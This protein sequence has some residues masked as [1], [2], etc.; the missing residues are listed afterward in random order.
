MP[1]IRNPWAPKPEF[2]FCHHL[3]RNHSINDRTMDANRNYICR[4]CK[5][6]WKDGK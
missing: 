2:G 4:Y 6:P 1:P 3:G 5:Q